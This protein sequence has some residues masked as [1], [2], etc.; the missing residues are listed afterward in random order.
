VAFYRGGLALDRLF[1]KVD[2]F[3]IAVQGHVAVCSAIDWKLV[4]ELDVL[5]FVDLYL[6]FLVARGHLPVD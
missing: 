4:G 2:E 6:A 3:L 5:L 1:Y